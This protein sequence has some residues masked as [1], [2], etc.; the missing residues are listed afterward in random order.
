MLK[1][2][3]PRHALTTDTKSLEKSEKKRKKKR[4]ENYD[5][6]NRQQLI[7]ISK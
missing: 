1:I 2:I 6:L 3:K 7:F 4:E 5:T